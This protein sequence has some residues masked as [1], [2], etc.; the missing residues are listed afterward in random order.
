MRIEIHGDALKQLLEIKEKIK[1]NYNELFLWIL[2]RIKRVFSLEREIAH[3]KKQVKLQNRI[4]SLMRKKM[5]EMEK[6]QGTQKP[7]PPPR[8]PRIP[9]KR[10]KRI[11][12]IQTDNV[13]QDLQTELDQLFENG[14]SPTFGC[15]KNEA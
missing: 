1:G 13:K 6:Q 15:K 8:K 5:E 14:L 9:Y 3:Y 4:A 12:E 11:K 7:P 10:P 2:L